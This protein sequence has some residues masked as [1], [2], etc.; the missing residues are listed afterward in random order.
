MTPACA[1]DEVLP[2]L[3]AYVLN[4]TRVQHSW[5]RPEFVD[6]Y[7]EYFFQMAKILLGG[8]HPFTRTLSSIFAMRTILRATKGNAIGN[9]KG[10]FKQATEQAWLALL[11]PKPIRCMN[12]NHLLPTRWLPWAAPLKDEFRFGEGGALENKSSSSDVRPVGHILAWGASSFSDEDSK[13]CLCFTLESWRSL[14]ILSKPLAS[15]GWV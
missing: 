2:L 15:S 12:T 3:L 11:S 1:P 9:T 7:S 14:W 10:V 6:Q 4:T 8:S 13:N 5:E